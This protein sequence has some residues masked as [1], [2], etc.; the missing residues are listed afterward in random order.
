MTG[1][2]KKWCFLVDG[3][4]PPRLSDFF[5]AQGYGAMH[6]KELAM[7]RVADIEIW[8]RAYREEAVIVTKDKDFASLII[9]RADVCSVIWVRM[10]NVRRGPLLAKFESA[11]QD[12]IQALDNGDKLIE[13]T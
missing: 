9:S 11:M 13:L 7:E 6:I 3:N 4:L 1:Q 12:L 5:R 10:G 2:R 8:K